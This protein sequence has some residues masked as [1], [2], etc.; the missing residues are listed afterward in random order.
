LLRERYD[1]LYVPRNDVR[2]LRRNALVALGNVGSPE[3]AELAEPFLANG[4]EVLREHA[5]WAVAQIEERDRLGPD[6]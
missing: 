1:R 4:D 5:R 6:A 2:S 3:E